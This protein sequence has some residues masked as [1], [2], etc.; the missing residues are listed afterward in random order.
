MEKPEY[1]MESDDEAVRLDRKTDGAIVEAQA[2][3][4]GITRG[5]R[6]ADLGC[7]SG[8]PT[9][10]LNRLVQ[11]G[12]E[13]VGIDF[14]R[15][16]IDFAN[17]HYRDDGLSFLRRDIREPLDDLGRF[18]FVWVR[19]LLE[20]YRAEGVDLVN[21]ISAILKPG[22]ILC[23]IDLDFNCLI[24]HG[25]SPTLEDALAKVIRIAEEEYNFDPYAG[26]RLYA[27]LYDLGYLDI[28]VSVQP[29]GVIY[30]M[31]QETDLYNWTKKMAIVDGVP[32]SQFKAFAEGREG[33][34]KELNA[35]IN[36]PRRFTY[37]PLI[38]CRGI[39]P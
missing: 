22:G 14:S 32:E 12:G 5:M 8:K 30:G 37:T 16:R 25:L 23:L 35:F 38:A 2:S 31:A 19:F 24:Y 27:A 6:V 1:L 4:A 18:D 13:T 20:Y 28:N 39:K 17:A 7:G 34:L 9:F 26:R 3:W 29:H 36:D 15:Q 11:P 10:H 21:R 33:F